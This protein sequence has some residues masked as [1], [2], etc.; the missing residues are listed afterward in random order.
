V[1]ID[2]IRSGIHSLATSE[3]MDKESALQITRLFH[4]MEM[5]LRHEINNREGVIASLRAEIAQ[6]RLQSELDRISSRQ[7]Q[8]DAST[9]RSSSKFRR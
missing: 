9:P 6:S 4:A 7:L 2:E 3:K 1:R 8:E 5:L